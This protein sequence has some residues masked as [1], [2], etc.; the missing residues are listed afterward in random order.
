VEKKRVLL[1]H[2]YYQIGGGE[3]T[4]FESEKD[5]LVENGH[6]V[7]S[8]T[9][10]NDELKAAAWKLALLPFTTSWSMKTYF[11]VRRLIRK[12][13]ID[14]VHCH[15]TFPL[16]SPSVYYAARSMKVPVV[17]TIHNFRFLCPNGIFYCDGQICEQCKERNTFGPA[18]I[19]GCY[20]NSKLQTAVV[21]AMLRIHRLLGTYKK[22]NYIFLTEFNKRKFTEL[23]DIS[24]EN[25]FVK[26]NFV[27][28]RC[29]PHQ[30]AEI[31]PKF[32]YMGRLEQNK[33]IDFLLDVWPELPEQYEL[34]IY[35]D[36][37]FRGLC[38]AKAKKYEN[39]HFFGFCPQ[40]EI[41]RD[42]ENAQALLFMS[43][44]YEG[45]PM[46]LAE[47]FSLG[48]PVISTDVGNH[49]D[50]V[51]HSGGGVVFRCGDK[52]SFFEALK[53]VVANNQR[54][55]ACAVNYFREHLTKEINYRMLCDIYDKA[56]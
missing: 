56:R 1:V 25:I 41:F 18:I 15:N 5:M 38:E 39:I 53:N 42:L 3:H 9:R 30:E 22:L 34:H 40:E 46:T 10:S 14:I 27:K 28:E 48:R 49:C 13:Q 2:N 20:R 47:T 11:D 43:S 35:G 23:V 31:Q 36:G 24:G 44:W 45:Y 7:Y 16:I 32:I 50:V 55:S 17:Q 26:P 12:K 33:G 21:A 29:S 37:T 4:V 19:K 6:A 51:M 54:Y 8:Y 52:D